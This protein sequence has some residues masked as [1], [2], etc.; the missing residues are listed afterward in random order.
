MWASVDAIRFRDGAELEVVYVF[1]PH[2]TA[3]G[4]PSMQHPHLHVANTL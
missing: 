3:Q 4:T 1:V 2:A